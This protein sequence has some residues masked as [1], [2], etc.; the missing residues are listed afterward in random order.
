M[1]CLRSLVYIQSSPVELLNTSVRK[2]LGLIWA[3]LRTQCPVH[4][5]AGDREIQLFDLIASEHQGTS[6]A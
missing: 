6:C 1:L 4:V 2:K 3:A 5:A